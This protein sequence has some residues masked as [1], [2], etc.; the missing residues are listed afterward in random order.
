MLRSLTYIY[1]LF[2]MYNVV[3]VESRDIILG[4]SP[5]VFWGCFL[6]SGA[7]LGLEAKMTRASM[8]V[9]GYKRI[10]C[11]GVVDDKYKCWTWTVMLKCG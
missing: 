11:N 4:V 2:I 8:Y 5:D 10:T 7:I 3:V 9:I 6:E 1:L